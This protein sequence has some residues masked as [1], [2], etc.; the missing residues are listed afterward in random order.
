MEY[1]KIS[2]RAGAIGPPGFDGNIKVSI[3]P[4]ESIEDIVELRN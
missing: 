3:Y 4:I 1:G 2:I